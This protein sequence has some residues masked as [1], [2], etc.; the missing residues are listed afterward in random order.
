MIF[1]A[2][3]KWSLESNGL[4]Y[5]NGMLSSIFRS[6]PRIQQAGVGVQIMSV[7]MPFR[8]EPCLMC[9]GPKERES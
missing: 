6:S 3:L 9:D 4:E 7:K 2:Y 1:L 8:Y 5:T